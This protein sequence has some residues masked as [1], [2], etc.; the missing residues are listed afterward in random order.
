MTLMDRS[1]MLLKG[2]KL[3][4]IDHTTHIPARAYHILTHT[5][6]TED[7]RDAFQLPLPAYTVDYDFI[8]MICTGLTLSFHY[9]PLPF[10]P[11][12]HSVQLDISEIHT[13]HT[14]VLIHTQDFPFFLEEKLTT[15]ILADIRICLITTQEG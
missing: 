9:N 13:A 14:G 4:Q 2:E 1:K 10:H 12:T 11:F 6:N 7:A 8:I 15:L 5:H 3:L